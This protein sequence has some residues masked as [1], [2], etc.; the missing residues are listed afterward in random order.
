MDQALRIILEF[1]SLSWWLWLFLILLP[2]FK[3]TWL[4]W[5]NEVYEHSDEM[6]MVM[7]EMRIPREI[8]KSPRGMEQALMS[9]HQLGNY[10]SDFREKWWDGEITRW[11]S[12]E[13]VSFGGEVKFFIRCYYK[14]RGLVESAIFSNYQD[15]EL[16]EVTEDYVNRFPQNVQEMYRQGYDTWGTE[17]ILT[18][19]DAYPTKI[20]T[21]FEAPDEERQ[22]DPISNFLEVL[23]K[24][25]KEEIVAIQFLIAP[26]HMSKWNDEW[27]DLIAKLKETDPRKGSGGGSAKSL[28]DFPGGPLPALSVKGKEAAPQPVRFT[29]RTPGETSVL[30]AVEQ[31]LSKLPF[32]TLIR[33]IYFSP[34]EL[35]YDSFPRR[36]LVG[37][38]NQY[39]ALDLNSFV[40]NY[41]VSTRTRIWNWPHIFPKIR[42]EYR[43]QRLLFNFRR[44]KMPPETWMGRLITSYPF[45]WN[46]V[47]HH[48]VLT[49]QCLATLYH[50]PTFLVLTAPH[51][52][53]V[54]SKKGGAPAGVA[55][56]GDESEI[57]RFK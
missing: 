4:F 13:M 24:L 20:Y 55:I 42:N 22:Y 12:L 37:S 15:I 47:S 43:K 36:G 54:E 11:A 46:F 8:R 17:M 6:R 28:L 51:I 48:I 1:L 50:P 5:R 14:Q 27:D 3:S 57:E 25:K 23:S 31:N 29:V 30:E 35:F 56:Y 41:A 33:F 32:Q 26:Q 44:R 19:D 40:Q 52:E 2:L 34:K 9:I 21:E 49:T 39:A 53:R 10:P 18:R 16:V 45:N 7:L 38:F